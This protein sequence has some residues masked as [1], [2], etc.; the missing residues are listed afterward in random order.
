MNFISH[1]VYV[2]NKFEN[3]NTGIYT[4]AKTIE[5]FNLDGNT[6][7]NSLIVVDKSS[8]S[9]EPPQAFNKNMFIK[10]KSDDK[11]ATFQKSLYNQ[12]NNLV[13]TY[14]HLN[15]LMKTSEYNLFK[16]ENDIHCYVVH[17]GMFLDFY[18]HWRFDYLMVL[19]KNVISFSS[20]EGWKYNPEAGSALHS[21]LL[22]Q[23]FTLE[24]LKDLIT[25]R[26]IIE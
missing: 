12:L 19:S 2:P 13:K 25:C 1:F 8:I 16:E 4:D 15:D 23:K 11:G 26:D 24:Y 5:S 10:L 3:I 6:E 18:Y 21:V 20:E 7:L 14:N 9:S 17:G 22:P